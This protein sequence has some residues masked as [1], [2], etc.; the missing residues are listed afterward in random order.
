MDPKEDEKTG[1]VQSF[2]QKFPPWSHTGSV[3][4]PGVCPTTFRKL[5]ELE[6]A[7]SLRAWAKVLE[8][9]AV[10]L[11][12]LALGS[13]FSMRYGC[14]PFGVSVPPSRD[15][16]ALGDRAQEPEEKVCSQNIS[17]GSS[18]GTEDEGSF[19]KIPTVA[20]ALTGHQGIM[21]YCVR[22]GKPAGPEKDGVCHM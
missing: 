9:D 19:W 20:E 21:P 13:G 6:E 2:I 4:A 12:G 1:D 11:G 17:F 8:S 18:L 16:L 22:A 15:Y 5:V 10:M 14:A 3:H 7:K